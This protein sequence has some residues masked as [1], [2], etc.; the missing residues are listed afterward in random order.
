M[1]QTITRLILYICILCICMLCTNAF[2]VSEKYSKV[3]DNIS[4]IILRISIEERDNPIMPHSPSALFTDLIGIYEHILYVYPIQNSDFNREE[5]EIV[6]QFNEIEGTSGQGYW[7]YF[8]Y[9]D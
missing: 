5:K 1:K 8:I 6:K 3:P 9:I 2:A 4:K 7:N